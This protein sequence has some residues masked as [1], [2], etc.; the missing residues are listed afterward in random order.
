MSAGFCFEC[1]LFPCARLKQLDKR[2]RTKYGMSMLENLAAIR[3]QGMETFLAG[4]AIRWTCPSCGSL[5]C[6]HRRACLKCKA[7]RT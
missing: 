4:Q 2:Y 3:D 6:V 1:R 7:A 5:L